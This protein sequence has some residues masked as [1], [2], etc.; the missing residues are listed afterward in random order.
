VAHLG[1]RGEKADVCCAMSA[2]DVAMSDASLDAK[3]QDRHQAGGYRRIELITGEPRRRRWSAEEKARILA[4]SFE[5]GAKV[6]DV[7]LRHGVNRALLWTW[8]RQA[9][10]RAAVGEPAF[11]PL[12]VL[13][14]GPASQ[15][16]P[17][18]S[19]APDLPLS[20][21]SVPRG[22]GE[23]E[24]GQIE[25]EIGD[26]RVRISGSVDAAALRQVLR[27]FHRP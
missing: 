16:A 27:H 8:R 19:A 10:K 17:A 11:V 14:D 1:V 6:S 25:V 22:R 2:E 9:R 23:G 13:D 20:T 21:A 12:R 15:A 3:H 18:V 24:A 4:A 5:P 7:A 26:A